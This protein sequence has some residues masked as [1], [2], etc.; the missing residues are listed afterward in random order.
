MNQP[1]IVIADYGIGNIRSVWNS[2]AALG[3][4]KVILSASADI[5]NR[6][7]AIILPGVGAF[8]ECI[9][10]L[11]KSNLDS[12]LAEAV[13]G[14]ERPLLGICVGMQLL[15]SFSDE[16]GRHEGLGWIPGAVRRLDLPNGFV[17][18]H[19]GWNNVYP[20][21]RAPLFSNIRDAPDFYFD[22]SYCY[23]CDDEY[24]LAHCDYGVKIVAAVQRAHIFG[25][26]F[27]PE[28]SQNN[29]LKLFRSFFECVAQ[30]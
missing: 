10:N 20:V 27:H 13:L 26:Q 7:D 24:V 3:Y 6:A 16:G 21:R 2:V 23:D 11:K 5:L 8:A 4:K 30:C 28:K 12:L 14:R 18:P 29:G 22:H 1:N 9:F 19:V 15:A 25:V 17:V